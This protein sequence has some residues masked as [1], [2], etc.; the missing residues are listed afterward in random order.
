[1]DENLIGRT[2]SRTVTAI[3][4]SDK[5]HARKKNA[6]DAF[7]GELF[8]T[9]TID[10]QKGFLPHPTPHHCAGIVRFLIG[11]SA[12]VIRGGGGG[13]VNPDFKSRG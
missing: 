5:S 8:R 6:K 2:G 11:T 13:G 12:L 9:I 4:I 10:E 1:M 7:F 3:E